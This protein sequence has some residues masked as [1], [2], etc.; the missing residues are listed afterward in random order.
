MDIHQLWPFIVVPLIA[1]RLY[2]RLRRTF[3]KQRFS[4]RRLWITCVL[5]PIILGIVGLAAYQDT[6]AVLSLLG[7]IVGGALLAQIGLRH[8]QFD[9]TDGEYSYTP[10]TYIG[11]GLSAIFLGRIGYKVMQATT[12][13]TMPPAGISPINALVCGLLLAYYTSYAIGVLRWQKAHA[14]ARATEPVEAMS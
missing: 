9:Y 8:T 6:T 5:L 12:V 13:G 10:H 4:A 3:G 2:S 1:W 11:L 7:G 14:R